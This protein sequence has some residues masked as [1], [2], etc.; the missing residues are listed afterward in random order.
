MTFFTPAIFRFLSELREHNSRDWFETHRERYEEE[1]REPARAFIMALGAPLGELCPQILADPSRSGGSLFR[2]HR[3]TR[4]S[5]DKS[6]YKTHVG[7]QFRHRDCPREVHSPAFYLHL[8]PGGCFAGAGLW[9]PDPRT[10]QRVRQHMDG[11][12]PA[13]R[14]LGLELLGD[15]IVRVPRGFAPD[16]PLAELLRLKDITTLVPLAEGQVCAPDFLEVFLEVCRHQLPL[17]ALLARS[18]DLAW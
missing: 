17:L 10:L 8:E 1:V 11:H 18:L 15:R 7:A 16:H 2:I 3:D 5:A 4:F 13:W 6:P 12:V 14:S 9:H